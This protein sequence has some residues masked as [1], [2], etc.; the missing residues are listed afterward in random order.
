MQNRFL[1]LDAFTVNDSDYCTEKKVNISWVLS[2]PGGH[3]PFY[4]SGALYRESR[5]FGIQIQIWINHM[6]V[7]L[8]QWKAVLSGETKWIWQ[9]ELR[10]FVVRVIRFD[11]LWSDWWSPDGWGGFNC[12]WADFTA[13]A[14]EG[15]WLEVG[16]WGITCAR[17]RDRRTQRRMEERT[18]KREI[19]DAWLTSL[20]A[21]P[22]TLSRR[23]QI[24]VIQ[25]L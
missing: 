19:S 22:T 2:I 13:K 10:V 1:V 7:V 8:H 18:A 9:Y 21:T 20:I 16:V 17:L 25:K 14:T 3:H 24:N 6:W 5:V 15:T 4:L 12:A 23:Q 11:W